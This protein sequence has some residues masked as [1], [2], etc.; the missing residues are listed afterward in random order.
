[1]I[2]SVFLSTAGRMLIGLATLF[3]IAVAAK[4]IA[5][6]LDDLDATSRTRPTVAG[7][8]SA[9]ED[10][11]LR[12]GIVLVSLLLLVSLVAGVLGFLDS[13]L[14]LLA[15]AAIL[16]LP[17]RE[18]RS[19]RRE[20]SHRSILSQIVS[21]FPAVANESRAIAVAAVAI[22]VALGTLFIRRW[23]APPSSWDALTYHLDFPAHW[24]LAGRLET[25]QQGAG[26]PS[27]TYYPLATEQ[28]YFWALSVTRSDWWACL[29][30]LPALLL[31]SL[32]L[33]GIA[34]EMG[35]SRASS[36]W[37]IL[38]WLS[39]PLL[40]RQVGEAETEIWFASW[41]LSAVRFGL[42]FGAQ[43]RPIDLAFS[44][45]SFGIG[46]GSKYLGLLFLPTITLVLATSWRRSG[47]SIRSARKAL[48]WGALAGAL[49]G[50]WVYARNMVTGGN[51][52][53]PM[54]LEALGF[55]L[56]PGL[57][58]ASEYFGAEERGVS[59][60]RFFWSIRGLLDGGLV[61]WLSLAGC[62]MAAVA[63]VREAS[64]RPWA[65]RVV[66]LACVTTYLVFLFFVP[67]RQH[68]YFLLPF[69]LCM[70]FVATTKNSLACA[71]VLAGATLS[72]FYVGK[73]VVL[74]RGSI[75][76]PWVELLFL[77]GAIVSVVSIA[78][79]VRRTAS[80]SIRTAAMLGVGAGLLALLVGFQGRYDRKRFSFW[81]D[82]WSHLFDRTTG[83]RVKE[84][85]A[86]WSRC[87]SALAV[88][89]SSRPATVSYSGVNLP[90]PL[91]GN[92]LRNR[93]L[94]VPATPSLS[95]G[96]FFWG[97]ELVDPSEHVSEA[98]WLE[99]LR[100]EGVEYV[101]VFRFESGAWPAELE[102][103]ME[104]PESLEA[105]WSSP[106]AI[107]FRTLRS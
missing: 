30:Q 51:P 104:S 96:R 47:V 93:V 25:L 54:R 106:H 92:A 18:R 3:T 2:S 86:D 16:L 69:A 67:Y 19:E 97:D 6:A 95:N 1:M 103:G 100:L 59:L 84:D 10:H 42:S 60:P 66:A 91:R 56:L 44:I 33:K 62:V 11:L 88:A 27:P 13:P 43:A 21:N 4:R 107:I 94:F 72:L 81:E 7:S 77:V 28:L 80:R 58:E 78:R 70:P 39:T 90:Y 89:T 57:F 14:A 9:G 71:C 23:A 48:L 102:W 101:C 46:V 79:I 49:A 75:P 105:V 82:A 50:G 37:T 12:F 20:P 99:R 45:L 35:L 36:A 32:A 53:L 17:F 26:D 34:R 85:R 83:F 74:R 24:L 31:G 41:M 65:H 22:L 73:E 29:A 15:A 98:L 8:G 38:L 87:W 52:I 55:T 63:L 76:V 68:K 64:G 61:L 5:F 40:L